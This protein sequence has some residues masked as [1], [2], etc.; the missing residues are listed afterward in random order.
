MRHAIATLALLTA[1]LAA[2]A[3]AVQWLPAT[4]RLSDGRSL[5]GEVYVPGGRLRIYDEGKKRRYSVRLGEM[6]RLENRIEREG[7][8]EKW[9]FRET[10]LDDKIRTG[11][12]Y[13]VR[14][15]RTRVGFADGR[16]VEGHLVAKT[17]Y[18]RTNGGRQRFILCRKQEGDVGQDLSELTYVRSI[19]LHGGGTGVRGTIEGAIRAP[20]GETVRRVLALNTDASYAVD[21][22][23]DPATRTFRAEG[24]TAGS[25]DLVVVTNRAVYAR[26]GLEEEEGA[27]RLHGEQVGRVQRWVD[28]LRDF[29]H[30]Q[31]I[32]YAAGDESRLLALIWKD[33]RGGT[34]LRGMGRL[35]RYEVWAMHRPAN[36]WQIG[37]RMFLWRTAAADGDLQRLPV[38]ICPALSGHELSREDPKVKV[39]VELQ[40]SQAEPI[41]EP[42]RPERGKD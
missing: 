3:A 16:S 2:E 31:R 26:F 12:H 15:Y 14:E 27:G 10:G 24:C 29:F 19:Q 4:V 38:V 20:E 36:Q 28:R 23:W 33:R 21:A 9:L 32:L 37:K 7:T 22:T 40:R 18:V 13:P 30:D 41:P 1:L 11:R 34:T 25:W 17:L 42:P 35:H 5:T 8:A 6:T 39:T